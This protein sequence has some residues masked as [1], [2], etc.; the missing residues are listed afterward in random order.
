MGGTVLLCEDGEIP[1]FAKTAKGG[2]PA[3]ANEGR[4]VG[5]SIS[6]PG[7]HDPDAVFCC[8]NAVNC[9]DQ[10]INHG[11]PSC[12][13]VRKADTPMFT[14]WMCLHGVSFSFG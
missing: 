7:P 5:I 6:I 9:P 12:Y 3:T 13:Q 10:G 8:V 11:N 14:S 2:P 1:P 4:G